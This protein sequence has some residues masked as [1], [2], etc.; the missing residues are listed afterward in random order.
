MSNAPLAERMRPKRLEGIVG[1]SHILG[2][3]A[4]AIHGAAP[5]SSFLGASRGW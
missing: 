1:Q 3:N 2:P 4:H 5:F